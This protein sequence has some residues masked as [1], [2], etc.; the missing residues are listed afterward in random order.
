[1]RRN[2]ELNLSGHL[3]RT[4]FTAEDT[5]RLGRMVPGK[6]KKEG[7]TGQKTGRVSAFG[8]RD[9][10]RG[11]SKQEKKSRGIIG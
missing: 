2:H 7:G 8:M 5:G 11:K 9:G 1:M 3:N 4:I 10:G 6:R